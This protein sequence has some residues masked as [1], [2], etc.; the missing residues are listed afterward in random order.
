MRE[1][2]G[3]VSKSQKKLIEADANELAIAI[4]ATVV[5]GLLLAAITGNLKVR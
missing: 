5:G 1:R 3:K 4:V 2:N